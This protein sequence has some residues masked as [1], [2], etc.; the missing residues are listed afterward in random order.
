MMSA[1][2]GINTKGGQ[3]LARYVWIGYTDTFIALIIKS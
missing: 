2:T 3:K 1:E